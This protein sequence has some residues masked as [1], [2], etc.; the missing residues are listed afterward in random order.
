MEMAFNPEILEICQTLP[1]N[2]FDMSIKFNY[3]IAKEVNDYGNK[4]WLIMRSFFNHLMF[5]FA[6]RPHLMRGLE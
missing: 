6:S 4:Y 2:V 1:P 3:Q 5:M